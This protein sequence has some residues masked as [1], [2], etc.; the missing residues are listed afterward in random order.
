MTATTLTTGSWFGRERL[1]RIQIG[2]VRSLP[3][4]NVVTMTSSKLKREGQQPAGQHRACAARE[5]T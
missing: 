3:P 5:V 2:S 4:V 1:R